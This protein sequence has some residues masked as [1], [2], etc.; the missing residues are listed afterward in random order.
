MPV[1]DSDP[2]V[3][4]MLSCQAQESKTRRFCI[5]IVT[6]PM[7]GQ[8]KRARDPPRH[9]ARTPLR[10]ACVLTGGSRVTPAGFGK[11][12]RGA[13]Y[14]CRHDVAGVAVEIVAG[15]TESQSDPAQSSSPGLPLASRSYSS[16]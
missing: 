7:E 3:P 15:P 10:R 1:H 4:A 14:E 8:D 16:A 6:L 12:L 5:G 2:A 11:A 9:S 13:R